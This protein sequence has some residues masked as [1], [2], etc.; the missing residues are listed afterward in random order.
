[1][2]GA[3]IPSKR[4]WTGLLGLGVAVVLLVLAASAATAVLSAFLLANCPKAPP[5]PSP[6]YHN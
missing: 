3:V 2:E 5:P 1:M 6:R 4:P